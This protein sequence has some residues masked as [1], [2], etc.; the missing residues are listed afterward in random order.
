M[1]K[2]L[3]PK[4]SAA[5]LVTALLSIS[6]FAQEDKKPKANPA[7]SRPMPTIKYD[8]NPLPANTPSY[9]PVV[10]KVAPSVVTISTSKMVSGKT[11]SPGMGRDNPLFNDP[12]FRRFF[13]I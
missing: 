1:K 4:L 10:E 6:S 11:P 3:Y 13:G 12:T 2:L 8:P 7:A 9:A 5:L